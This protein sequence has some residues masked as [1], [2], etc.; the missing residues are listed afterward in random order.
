MKWSTFPKW[1]RLLDAKCNY[2]WV[3]E[4]NLPWLCLFGGWHICRSWDLG[5]QCASPETDLSIRLGRQASSLVEMRTEMCHLYLFKLKSRLDR[6]K[7][8]WCFSIKIIWE[9]LA[10]LLQ[11]FSN[12]E[13]ILKLKCYWVFSINLSTE[14]LPKNNSWKISGLNLCAE[15]SQMARL[16]KY[17][18]LIVFIGHFCQC[19]QYKILAL[20]LS[21]LERIYKS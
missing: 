12:F 1:E 4:R 13:I 10:L 21:Y 5:S 11:I 20:L 3:I 15:W 19:C 6:M 7:K 8:K 2:R 9:F 17:F 14:M 16:L 18:S